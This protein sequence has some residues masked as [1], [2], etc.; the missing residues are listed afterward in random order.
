MAFAQIP[1]HRPNDIKRETFADVSGV[2]HP[3]GSSPRSYPLGTHTALAEAPLRVA[4]R[5]AVDG[6][7]VVLPHE[8]WLGE[9]SFGVENDHLLTFQQVRSKPQ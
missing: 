3:G 1:A 4:E 6:V 8:Q 5:G 2:D 9:S 7:C